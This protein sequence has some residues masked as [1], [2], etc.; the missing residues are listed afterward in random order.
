MEMTAP[1]STVHAATPVRLSDGL[2]VWGF[3]LTCLTTIGVICGAW[4]TTKENIQKNSTRIDNV[5]KQQEKMDHKLDKI[6]DLLIN[7]KKK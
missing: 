5:E 3:V 1:E 2:K 4:V 6:I 7:D